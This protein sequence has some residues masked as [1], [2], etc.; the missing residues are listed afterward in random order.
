MLLS[1]NDKDIDKPI[2]NYTDANSP[3]VQ[4]IMNLYSMEPSFYVDLNRAS[5]MMDQSKLATL[6][7]FAKAIYEILFWGD[8]SDKKRDDAL[9]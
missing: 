2:S 9:K 3:Q 8:E 7:P 1:I 5:M 6:G 4:L